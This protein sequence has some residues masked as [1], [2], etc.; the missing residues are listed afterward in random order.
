MI[1]LA[2]LLV[3]TIFFFIERVI[4]IKKRVQAG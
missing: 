3:L 1:P 2:I 4:A